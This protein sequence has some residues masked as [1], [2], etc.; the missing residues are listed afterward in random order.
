MSSTSSSSHRCSAERTT[1]VV[2]AERH[3]PRRAKCSAGVGRLAKS[4]KQRRSSA[5][6]MQS[7]PEGKRRRLMMVVR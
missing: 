6:L 3:C 5:A 4:P 2:V 1:D 7:S